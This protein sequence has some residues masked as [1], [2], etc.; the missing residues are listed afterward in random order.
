MWIGLYRCPKPRGEQA[1]ETLRGDVAY[2][3]AGHAVAAD[4]VQNAIMWDFSADQIVVPYGSVYFVRV[5]QARSGLILL[6]AP[7]TALPKRSKDEG[8]GVFSTDHV[9]GLSRTM[10]AMGP[11]LPFASI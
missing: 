10:P 3:E 6:I 7:K 8:S 1:E 2:H 9:P 11:S 5:L 4:D